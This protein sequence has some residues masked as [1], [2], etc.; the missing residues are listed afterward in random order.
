MQIN[1]AFELNSINKKNVHWEIKSEDNLI[2]YIDSE[3]NIVTENNE[4]TEFKMEEMVDVIYSGMRILPYSEGNIITAIA[5]YITIAKFGVYKIIN[6]VKGIELEG[7]RIR[8][9]G[10]CSGRKIKEALRDDYYKFI[11]PSKLNSKG[12]L[13]MR[14]LIFTALNIKHSY[15][16]DK[17]V[18]LFVEDIIPTQA[19]VA[20][21]GLVILVNPYKVEIFGES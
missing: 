3:G 10:F 14:D 19:A 5:R 11:K 20:I 2:L 12:E 7:S 18:N 6:D 17:F 9:R 8:G 13:E 1:R 16:F 15:D 21:E 4:W